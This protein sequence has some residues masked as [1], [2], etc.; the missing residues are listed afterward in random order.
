MERHL[1]QRLVRA[2]LWRAQGA[3]L[4]AEAAALGRR[5]SR[6]PAEIV[7]SGGRRPSTRSPQIPR[8]SASAWRVRY[9]TFY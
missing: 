2:A 7:R 9:C 8:G 1:R 6:Q 5:S 4:E 3:G